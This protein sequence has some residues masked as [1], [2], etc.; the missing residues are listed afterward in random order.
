M[1]PCFVVALGK[2]YRRPRGN[3]LVLAIHILIITVGILQLLGKP[4]YDPGWN[5][6]VNESYSASSPEVQ[7]IHGWNSVSSRKED[8]HSAV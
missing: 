5:L 3:I 4:R 1:A 8:K 2:F 6:V 7:T